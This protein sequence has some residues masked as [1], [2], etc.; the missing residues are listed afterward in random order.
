MVFNQDLYILHFFLTQVK[1]V[2]L[3]E[4]SVREVLFDKRS[5]T[6]QHHDLMYCTQG[7]SRLD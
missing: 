5:Q 7:P 4:R 2:V 3:H 1:Q 6:P